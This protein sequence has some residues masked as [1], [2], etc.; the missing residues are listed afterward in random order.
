[1]KLKFL[2]FTLFICVIGFSQNKGTIAGVLLDKDANNQPLPFA[3][4]AIKGTKIGANTDVEGKY[5]INIAPGKYIMQFSFVGYESTE[6]PVTVVANETVIANSSLGSGSY[7]LKDVVIKSNGG[8]REKETALLLEQK[9]AIEMKQVIGAQELSRKGV[10]DAAVAVVKTAGVSKQEGVKNVFVRGLGDRYNST[11]LNGMPLPSE[12]PAYKNISLDFFSSNIIKNIN[13]NKT[14]SADLYGDNAGANIDISSKELDKRAT[15]SMSAGNGINISANSIG[16]F[17]VADGAYSYF[18]FLQNGRNNPITNLNK[19]DFESNFKTN[20]VS[21]KINSNFNI[22]GGGK[23]NIGKNS[24]SLF[25]VVSSNSEYFYS[26]GFLGQATYS[27]DYTRRNDANRWD[28]KATQSFLGNAKYKFNNGSVS[29][30]SLY[31]HN[32]SQYVNRLLGFD[33]DINGNIG[34]EAAEKSLV[35]RQQNNDNNLFSNQLL[36]DYKFSDKISVNVGGVYSKLRGTEPDRKINTYAYN[37]VTHTYSAAS[38]SAAQTMRYFSTLDEND[39]SAKGEI[40]YTFNPQ[41]NTP[42]VLTL[43]GNYR[44][45]DRTFNF[46]ELLYDFNSGGPTMDPKN[47]DLVLNQAGI[48]SGVFHLITGRGGANNPNALSPFYY[49]AN[50]DIIA[51]YLQLLY[52]FS[53]KF[54]AQIGA[55]TEQIKQN[56]YWDTNLSSTND[57]T[58][59]PSKIDKN[60]ILPSLNL[61]YAIN[62]KNAVRFSASETYT[63]PQFKEMAQFLYSDINSNE[64]GNPYLVPSTDYN[65]DC[66]YDYYLS[67]KELI[68]FGGFYKYIDNPISRTQMNSPALEY[69]YVNTSK[70][71]VLG[72]EL[73]VRKTLYN[74]DNEIRAK[75]FSWGF[76][77]SYLYSEQTQNNQ[78]TGVISTN[79]THEK[80]KMQGASPL[81]LNTDL[82]FTASN[83]QTSFLSTL[84]FNYFYDKVYTVGTNVRENIIEKAVPTLDF[85]N[86]FEL[87]QY[88]L[89]I[90]FGLKNMLN[91]KFWLTQQTTSTVTNE[92]NETLISSYKK[93]QTFVFGLNWQL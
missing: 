78:T 80:G 12:D 75:D 17:A 31:I 23:F 87:K 37:D 10:S 5:T 86:H 59:K 89:E 36:A 8:S 47:P 33:D 11:T 51:G 3:N 27:G 60:Y 4:V 77:A 67:K 38:D 79:F 74:F 35:I 40:N 71:F 16:E 58:T 20:S 9:N 14:F 29:F 93:G 68:S 44:T 21:N 85:I 69:S 45:T 18:G 55:R 34:T 92:T 30:N 19:Y 46:S 41:S 15:F 88:K 1:M 91:P 49:L 56:I 26:E 57:L 22:L 52:P 63:M 13:I 7:K 62:E 28:Y 70:A 43:G 6:V 64:Y 53:E 72:A 48:D 50:R 90:N 83:K 24:L 66:K 65:V 54:T 82:S 32:N 73:E 84:V 76:N 42:A 61:K 2:I 25:G 39:S 81:L